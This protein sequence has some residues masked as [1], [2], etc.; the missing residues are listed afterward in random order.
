MVGNLALRDSMPQL[1]LFVVVVVVVVD[2][3]VGI[4]PL[5]FQEFGERNLQELRAVE[6]HGARLGK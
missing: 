4:V 5:G 1:F 2:A 6:E 3:A